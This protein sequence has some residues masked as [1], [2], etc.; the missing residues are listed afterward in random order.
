MSTYHLVKGSLD[1]ATPLEAL[2][3]LE[4]ERDEVSDRGWRHWRQLGS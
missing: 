2:V 1:D 3:A 4:I